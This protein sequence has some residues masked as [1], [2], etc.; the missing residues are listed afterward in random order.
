MAAHLQLA[1]DYHTPVPQGAPYSVPLPGSQKSGRSA[2]YRHWRFK[3]GLLQSLDPNV[4]VY[5]SMWDGNLV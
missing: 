3:D 1:K 5:S 4:R 2:V